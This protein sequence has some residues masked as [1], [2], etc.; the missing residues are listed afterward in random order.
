MILQFSVL[1]GQQ[2]ANQIASDFSEQFG[3]PVSSGE[4]FLVGQWIGLLAMSCC[5]GLFSVAFLAGSGA[6]AGYIYDTRR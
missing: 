3:F 5:L 2:A 6:I 1:G 4:P